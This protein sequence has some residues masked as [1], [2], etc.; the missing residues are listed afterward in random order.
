MSGCTKGSLLY[1]KWEGFVSYLECW[2]GIFKV[3][4]ELKEV[5]VCICTLDRALMQV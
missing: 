2:T 1:L 4:P 3:A 5:V